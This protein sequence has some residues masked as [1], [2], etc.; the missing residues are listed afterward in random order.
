MTGIFSVFCSATSNKGIWQLRRLAEGIDTKLPSVKNNISGMAKNPPE[1]LGDDFLDEIFAF[2]T[3]WANKFPLAGNEGNLAGTA[4]WA[5]SMLQSSSGE[6]SSHVRSAAGGGGYERTAAMSPLDLNLKQEK[7]CSEEGSGSGKQLGE[8]SDTI[9]YNI[10][11]MAK[12]PPEDLGDDFFD[13][14]FAITTL[15][16]EFPLEENEGNLAGTAAGVSSMLQQSSGEG[17]SHLRSADGGGYEETASMSPLGLNLKQEKTCSEEASGS[18]KQLGEGKDSR[19]RAE[20]LRDYREEIQLLYRCRKS[21]SYSV[22][23]RLHKEVYTLNPGKFFVPSFIKA[24]SGNT[25][26]SLRSIISE[27][28]PGI[29]T[30]KML[31]PSFCQLLLS[32]VKN[33]EK[34]VKKKK[35]RIMHPNIMTS[36]GVVL[37]DFGLETMLGKLMED[38]ICPISKVFFPEVGGF[39]LDS[40]HGYVVHYG[41]DWAVDEGLH[42]DDSE[43]TLNVCLGNQFSGG[44]QYFGGIR[45]N[46][47]K[48]TRI[49]PEETLD[50]S[51]VP[52]KA[53]LHHG[54]HRNGANATTS[55]HRINLLL[56]CRSSV[57][58]EMEYQ[59]K[60]SSCCGWCQREKKERQRQSVSAT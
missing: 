37:D 51:H 1:G 46:K 54:R 29:Y 42:M 6:G 12:N 18:G 7:T 19:T 34:W 27:P 35:I 17:S 11:G 60:I 4:A 15:G 23:Q 41:K 47:H 39:T 40:H 13:E 59:K 56:W 33:F 49:E 8:G 50:Y 14:I 32:E 21:I 5:S 48:N 43:V 3:Y 20:K 53:V 44:E 52:G 25:A 9:P 24:V 30:F 45:C 28:S 57:F 58:R 31:Q 26:A 2:P 36:Y 22:I 38:F 55:G 10:S 16:S